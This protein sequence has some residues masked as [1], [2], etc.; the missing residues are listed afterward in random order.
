MKLKT[1]RLE[2]ARGFRWVSNLLQYQKNQ[3]SI[4]TELQAKMINNEWV[5]IINQI[6]QLNLPSVSQAT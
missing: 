4:F 3:S 6:H 1:Q 5:D 2:Q